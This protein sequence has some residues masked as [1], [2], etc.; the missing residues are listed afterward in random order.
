MPVTTSEKYVSSVLLNWT[1]VFS[2][3]FAFCLR[4]I[5]WNNIQHFYWSILNLNDIFVI[6]R[7]SGISLKTYLLHNFRVLTFNVLEV[8]IKGAR[9]LS[10]SIYVCVFCI[11]LYFTHYYLGWLSKTLCNAENAYVKGMWQPGFKPAFIL[12]VDFD[13]PYELDLSKIIICYICLEQSFL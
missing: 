5:Y 10:H 8:N 13:I 1:C 6:H 9:V 12:K 4:V 11:V 2:G 7:C 3:W